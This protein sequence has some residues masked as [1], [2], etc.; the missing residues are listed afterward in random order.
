[1]NSLSKDSSGSTIRASICA[2][3]YLTLD[4]GLG[5]F[6]YIA[7]GW[8]TT[9]THYTAS[10]ADAAGY[11]GATT[12]SSS[13]S[14]ST[15]LSSASTVSTPSQPSIASP[16]G[17]SGNNSNIGAIVGGVMGSLA[18]IG[19]FIFAAYLV[20]IYRI[21][22]RRKQP[23]GGSEPLNGDG[24]G[25]TSEDNTPTPL[26]NLS[27][28]PDGQHYGPGPGPGPGHGAGA[29]HGQAEYGVPFV[30]MGEMEQRRVKDAEGGWGPRELDSGFERG[31]YAHEQGQ[32]G[33]YEV[34]SVEKVA[35]MPVR[36]EPVEMSSG[37]EDHPGRD[38]REGSYG[39]ELGTETNGGRR[40]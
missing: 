8:T 32:S 21:R 7:C 6:Q 12:T 15:S 2:T 18:I 34:L 36:F 20:W 16:T 37:W 17:N 22:D 14:S 24:S 5:P 35:E 27:Y 3:A 38:G 30:S 28:S 40:R 39:H 10:Q 13:G 4:N 19:A 31:G 11:V 25:R 1:M 26:S 9:R 33:P 23:R 29:G